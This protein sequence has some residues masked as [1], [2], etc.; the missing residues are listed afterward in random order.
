M[1]TINKRRRKWTS[2][3]EETAASDKLSGIEA[4]DAIDLLSEDDDNDD[5]EDEQ[6]QQQLR[7]GR[8]D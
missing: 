1:A 5:D 3:K 7:A 4:E 8:G 6:Q 2:S